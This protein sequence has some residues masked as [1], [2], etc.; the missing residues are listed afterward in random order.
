MSTRPTRDEEAAQRPPL[1]MLE[2]VTTAYNL[3]LAHPRAWLT[4]LVVPLLIEI[5]A[6]AGFLALYGEALNRVPI[7]PSAIAG[8]V[9]YARFA[10]LILCLMIAYVFFAVSWHRFALL[11]P[12]ERPRLLPAVLGRHMRFGWMSFLVLLLV[13][14]AMLVPLVALILAQVESLI[15]ILLAVTLT[16]ALFV[17]WQLIFPAIALDRP[18]GFGQAWRLSRGHGLTLFWGFVLA[19]LPWALANAVLTDLTQPL[20]NRFVVTGAQPLEALGAMLLGSLLDYASLAVVVGM[21][22]GTYRHLVL[23]TESPAALPNALPSG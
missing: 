19:S 15:A 23:A 1:P 5:A 11:G 18:I 10:G 4:A 12:G 6:T 7:D 9:F 20:Q 17:R 8:P 16:V 3:L 2:I 14:L 13:L 21:L 22:S